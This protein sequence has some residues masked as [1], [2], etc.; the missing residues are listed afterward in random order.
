MT[1][2]GTMAMIPEGG[3]DR[4]SVSSPLFIKLI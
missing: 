4:G 2:S 1:D 3:C